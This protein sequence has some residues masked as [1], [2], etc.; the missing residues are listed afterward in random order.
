MPLSVV[1]IKTMESLICL[2]AQEVLLKPGALGHRSTG[3][4]FLLL[5]QVRAKLH[6]H[7][8]L[9]FAR[10]AHAPQLR[11]PN[12]ADSLARHIPILQFP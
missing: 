6:H 1:F 4:D 11:F 9:K 5:D 7:R 8:R 12:G 10:M 3:D 2:A